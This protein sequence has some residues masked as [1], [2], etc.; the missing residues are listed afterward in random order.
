MASVMVELLVAMS[1]LAFTVI[2]LSLSHL[3]EVKVARVY[4]FRA[5]AMELVD[6]EMETLVAGG[7][8]QAPEGPHPYH[9]RGEAAVNLPPG[10]FLLTRTGSRL[11]LEWTPKS[12]N[13]GG[14]VIREAQGR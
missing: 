14:R 12:K 9:V 6:G 3:K 4:Y 10:E 7:W 11:R 1:I 8:R 2:P 13:A 5:V